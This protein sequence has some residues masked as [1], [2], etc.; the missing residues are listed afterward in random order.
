MINTKSPYCSALILLGLLLTFSVSAERMAVIV[1]GVNQSALQ[2]RI[3]Q[4]RLEEILL[5]NDIETVDRDKI[6][7]LKNDWQELKDPT[8]F[9]T[10]E[11]IVAR[12]QHYQFD[13]LLAAYVKSDW[14]H[15]VGGIYLA[16]AHVDI[17]LVDSKAKVESHS[18]M[19]MGTIQA[20]ISEGITQNASLVNALRRAAESSMVKS[21]FEIYDPTLNKSVKLSLTPSIKPSTAQSTY[22]IT[23]ESDAELLDQLR[24]QAS[25]KSRLRLNCSVKVEG[26]DLFAIGVKATQM[27]LMSGKRSHTSQV[28]IYDKESNEVLNAFDIEYSSRKAAGERKKSH[29][30]DIEDCEFVNSWK[31]LAIT[32]RNQIKLFEV[33]RGIELSSFAFAKAMKKNSIKILRSAQ[34]D[35][36][37]VTAGDVNEYFK[38]DH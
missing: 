33:E 1:H 9:I 30:S 21:G 8:L 29:R 26:T 20:P 37:Q 27:S 2:L 19:P 4:T 16:S 36:I 6:K 5:D 18:S 24:K 7:A 10:A 17:R 15:G 28:Y 34:A 22:S 23:Q 32:T 12:Q 38:I 14:V 35:Y 11:D 31:Y 13:R 25:K 3:V